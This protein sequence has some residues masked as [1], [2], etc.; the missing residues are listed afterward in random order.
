MASASVA[1]SSSGPLIQ[2][3][4]S[5]RKT[6][7]DRFIRAGAAM[8]SALDGAEALIGSLDRLSGALE[9]D[10]AADA[11][12]ALHDAA[13]DLLALP[14]VQAKRR[15]AF[16]S[17]V[18][19]S[20]RLGSN[21]ESMRT[22]LRYLRAFSLNLKVTAAAAPEF[23]GFAQELME[24]IGLGAEKLTS[25]CDQLGEI[26]EQLLRALDFVG[27]LE[28][29]REHLLSTVAGDLR[30]SADA[31][32]R[33]NGEISLV[34]RQVGEVARQIRMRVSAALIAMQIGD[35]TRQ[36]IEHVQAGLALLTRA[37]SEAANRQADDISRS[38]AVSR[39]L[40]EQL[41]DLT[42]AFG[43]E[44]QRVSDNLLGLGGDAREVL[45]LKALIGEGRAAG[46][47]RE[48]ECK[49]SQANG[50]VDEIRAANDQAEQAGR[51]VIASVG[52]LLANVDAIQSVK[53]EIRYMAINTS[54]RCSRMGEA[55][56]P[57]NV[58]G[59]ELRAGADKLGEAADGAMADLDRFA[60]GANRFIE[61]ETGAALGRDLDHALDNIRRAG[62]GAETDLESV[63]RR[64][65]HV[66]EAAEHLSFDADFHAD[67]LKAL[68]E[69]RETLEAMA[70]DDAPAGSMASGASNATLDQLFKLYTMEREREIHRAHAPHIA[71][72]DCAGELDDSSLGE[73]DRLFANALF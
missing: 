11:N 36:R 30:A 60:E 3:L 69:A 40:L 65:A 12:R 45:R 64:S 10:A 34:A 44:A 26:D 71:L 33:H 28:G 37:D 13:A 1:L 2:T 66:A 62:D 16:E 72:G 8:A 21:I 63:A 24:R 7:E 58:I 43:V 9:G 56:R 25:F 35:T 27:T 42:D 39:L 47:L 38:G 19:A 70:A 14:A 50:V 23:S 67:L 53:T 31:I 52:A 48:L 18:E 41:T 57:V 6:L 61:Q 29:D 22:M 20:A 54:L 32:Q 4:E 17:L 51:A 49:V 73:D 5:V 55:G 68:D 15:A 59:M 46:F